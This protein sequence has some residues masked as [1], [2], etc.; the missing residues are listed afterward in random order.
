MAKEKTTASGLSLPTDGN[1]SGRRKII[2]DPGPLQQFEIYRKLL[3][4]DAA[5]QWVFFD[6]ELRKCDPFIIE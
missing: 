1:N 4:G 2:V 6:L 5:F 3:R